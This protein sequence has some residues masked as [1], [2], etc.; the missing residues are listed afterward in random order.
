MY[1]QMQ[2]NTATPTKLLKFRIQQAFLPDDGIGASAIGSGPP[3]SMG[4]RNRNSVNSENIDQGTQ[5]HHEYSYT[6]HNLMENKLDLLIGMFSEQ[7][8]AINTI[9]GCFIASMNAPRIH[10]SLPHQIPSDPP[11]ANHDQ[12]TY[13][14]FPGASPPP[15]KTPSPSTP[16]K[17][18]TTPALHIVPSQYPPLT[19]RPRLASCL[20][21]LPTQQPPTVLSHPSAPSPVH[22]AS[23]PPPTQPHRPPPGLRHLSACSQEDN[24]TNAVNNTSTEAS[25]QLTPERNSKEKQHKRK[26]KQVEPNSHWGDTA[27]QQMQGASALPTAPPPFPSSSSATSGHQ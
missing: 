21:P 5:T 26:N 11:S 1:T 12:T 3:G 27:Q 20:A 22:P 14:A 15:F 24:K 6:D 7:Q 9:M 4:Q 18:Q 16:G 17:E 13:Q 25:A 19:P 8:L 23:N 2:C 10:L